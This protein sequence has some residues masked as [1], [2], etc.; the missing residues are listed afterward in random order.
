MGIAYQNRLATA[1]R[2]ELSLRIYLAFGSYPAPLLPS[3]GVRIVGLV[4]EYRWVT[5][6]GDAEGRG[7]KFDSVIKPRGYISRLQ[8]KI[9]LRG[10]PNDICVR[11]ELDMVRIST[12]VITGIF[13]TH[14]LRCWPAFGSLVCPLDM[15]NCIR[16]PLCH[17]KLPVRP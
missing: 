11:I 10:V 1:L 15:G 14:K 12:R 17:L 9:R 4:A 6:C 8:V 13:A 16:L 3:F 2:H 5:V 7:I